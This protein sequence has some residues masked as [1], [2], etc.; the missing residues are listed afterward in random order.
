M[1]VISSFGNAPGTPVVD[2]KRCVRCGTC[3]AI[4][5]VE[6]LQSKNGNI[7]VDNDMNFGC[8]ACGQCMMVCPNGS[9]RV[10]GRNLAPSDIIDLPPPEQRATAEQLTALMLARRSIR[11]FTSD[12]VPRELL[13]RIIQAAASAPM[14]IPPTEVGI[15]AIVG[16]SK[17]AELS[18]DTANGYSGMLKVMGNPI[19]RWLSRLIMKKVTFDRFDSF[20]LPLGNVIVAGNQAGRDFVH[21][22][23]PAALLFYVSP[24]ADNTDAVIACTYAMLA[25]ESAGLGTCMIGCSAPILAR[26]KAL[27]EKYLIPEGHTPALVLIMGYHE[28]PH[29]K[30]VRRRFLSVNHL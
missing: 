30:A 14:G 20:I 29:K 17:V 2:S 19:V 28:H 9:I 3:A 5:P 6:V 13:D 22:H 23:A 18:R 16:R 11:H 27:K 15:T 7:T 21:Y 1:G 8:I 12:E 25:A 24:Y 4:C 10:T 26:S